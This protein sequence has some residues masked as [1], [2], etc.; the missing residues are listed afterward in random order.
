MED[1]V[2]NGRVVRFCTPPKSAQRQLQRCPRSPPLLQRQRR[3]V[4]TD[5]AG[6]PL[7]L[8]QNLPRPSHQAWASPYP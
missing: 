7:R 4:V 3:V 2:S 6:S 8:T 5:E 1:F